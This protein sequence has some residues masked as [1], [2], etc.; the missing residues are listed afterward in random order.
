MDEIEF[1]WFW[2]D[3]ILFILTLSEPVVWEN[4][5]QLYYKGILAAEK[6]FEK[7]RKKVLTNGAVWRIIINVVSETT[8][9]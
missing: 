6:N 9:P 1:K 7:T 4:R 5:F 2:I 8:D 3:D